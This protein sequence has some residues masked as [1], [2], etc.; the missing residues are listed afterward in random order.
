MPWEIFARH[1]VGQ[2]VYRII[3]FKGC[4]II[5]LPGIP[6]FLGLALFSLSQKFDIW[7]NPVV[8]YCVHLWHLSCAPSLPSMPIYPVSLRS[9]LKMSS[10]VGISKWPN[11]FGLRTKIILYSFFISARHAK[12]SFFLVGLWSYHSN[13]WWRGKLVDLTVQ[14]SLSS[15]YFLPVRSRCCFQVQIPN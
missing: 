4:Q 1:F 8:W 5:G 14:L 2:K 6:T 13:I 3:G 11:H 7:W 12:V 15:Y 10:H 9:A